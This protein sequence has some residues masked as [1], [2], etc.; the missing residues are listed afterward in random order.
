MSYV[1]LRSIKV[2]KP[3]R[4][5]EIRSPGEAVPEADSWANVELWVRRGYIAP[6][7]GSTLQP[8]KA[9][10]KPAVPYQPIA[11]QPEA[12]PVDAPA[13]PTHESLSKLTKVQLIQMGE[14]YG[15]EL[16]DAALKEELISSVLS[17]SKG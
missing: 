8:V 11:T 15:L 1:A 5:V 16:N 2:Q 17:A 9:A 4:T 7:D 13:G 14:K 3:D 12:P 10:R 6:A